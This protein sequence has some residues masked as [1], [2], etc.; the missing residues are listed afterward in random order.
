M[1][2]SKQWKDKKLWDGEDETT[3][4]THCVHSLVWLVVHVQTT[5]MI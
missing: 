3:V 1:G 2:L 4:F 5:V